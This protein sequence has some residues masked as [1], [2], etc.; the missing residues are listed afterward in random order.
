M[1]ASQPYYTA[2]QPFRC[3]FQ[4]GVPIL[5]Y[6][7]LGPRPSRVRLKGLYLKVS[8]FVRQLDELRSA[9]FTAARLAEVPRANDNG[10][11]PV[12]MTFDDGFRNVWEHGLEPLAQYGF[13][14]I[15]FLVVDLL[16]KSND[17][18]QTLGEVPEPLMDAVQVREWI[19]AGHEVGSHSLTHP[20]LT[21]LSLACA[22]EEISASKKK[23][24][25]FF[26]VAV[27]HFCYPYGDWNPQVR[28]LV[29]EV[30]YRTACTTDF[31]V[32]NSDVSRFELKRIT[33]RYRSRN[34]KTWFGRFNRLKHA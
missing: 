4:T 33:A 3:L 20:Y 15:Q 8:L 14:A 22:R 11:R 34:L 19:A 27:E 23:L 1:C 16:G 6:H 10:K 17:W 7:K 26:G 30:G 13:R 12:V 28:D 25:D 32:N 18:E 21:R 9:G 29:S 2:L 5:M 31:G 24:E